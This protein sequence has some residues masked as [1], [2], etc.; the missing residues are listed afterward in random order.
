MKSLSGK[1]IRRPMNAFMIFSKRH[2][3]LVHQL[4]PNSDNRTVS[5]KLGEWW[6]QL[7]PTKKSEYQN[8]A[9]R[10]KEA[11][12]ARHPEWKWCSKSSTN[13][14]SLNGTT[15]D[16]DTADEWE[17]DANGPSKK[18]R[19]SDVT[20]FDEVFMSLPMISHDSNGPMDITKSCDN[21]DTGILQ[22]IKSDIDES[23]P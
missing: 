3:A 10:V 9:T 7:P 19:R 6:Y 21:S 13:S 2:R 23:T 18:S 4:H 22:S 1:H 5:K 15:G 20:N 8:L 11:H 12:Y 14:A 17:G 16:C